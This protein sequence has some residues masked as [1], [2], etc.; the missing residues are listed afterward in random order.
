MQVSERLLNSESRGE[1]EKLVLETEEP[2]A[3][4]RFQELA[5]LVAAKIRAHSELS[6]PEPTLHTY[7]LT[8]EHEPERRLFQQDSRLLK[9]N[10]QVPCSFHGMSF[11]W[12]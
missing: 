5:V 9:A 3:G 2:S 10:C 11:P 4:D 8:N 7:T 6:H 1:F 12:P